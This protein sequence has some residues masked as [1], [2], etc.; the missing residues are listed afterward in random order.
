MQRAFSALRSTCLRPSGSRPSVLSAKL[1]LTSADLPTVSSVRTH[2]GYIPFSG[3]VGRKLSNKELFLK[4]LKKA[5]IQPV[6][7]VT[8]TFD[9]IREDFQSIRNFM[10]FWNKPKVLET[11]LKV[12]IKTDIVNDRRE[13]VINFELNDGRTLE[14]RTSKLTELEIAKIVN[15]YLLPLVKEEEVAVETKA[16]KGAG[17]SAKGKKGKK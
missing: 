12:L 4:E 16:A 17:S 2:L 5:N 8:Y 6:K 15:F 10:H 14:V 1:L 7:K 3:R 9:P 13:P 11:N